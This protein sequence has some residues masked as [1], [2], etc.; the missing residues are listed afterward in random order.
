MRQNTTADACD[1]IE[2]RRGARTAAL[3]YN[4]PLATHPQAPLAQPM[5]LLEIRNVTRR[6]GDFTAVDGVS[7]AIEAGEFFTLLGPSGC[8]KTTL[9][10]MI[11]GFDLPDGGSILLERRRSGRPAAGRAPRAHGVPELRAVS[12]HDGRGQR[13]LP[14]QDGEDA[15]R[16]DRRQGRRSARGRAAHRLRQALSARALRRPEAARRDRARAG[17]ASDGAAARRAA[18][19][20][21]RQAAR[22]DADRAHQPAEGSRHHVR[23]RDARP[24]RGARAVA[25]DRRDERR[26]RRAGGRA[27]ANL[28]LSEDAVRRRLHRP[29][30]SSVGPGQRQREWHRHRRRRRAGRRARGGRAPTLAP[31]PGRHRGAAPGEDPHRCGRAAPTPPT[32]T[33]AAPSPSFSTWAT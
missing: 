25:P 27:V 26:P 14:A 24:D 29:L 20:A 28:R 15:C 12:A 4:P 32:T 10:R 13:R 30:Q 21:R 22:R 8:G 16:A 31:R 7:L 6:F 3:L 1:A 18:R 9:L 23:L 5:A 17:H 33:S 19:R 2:P 11:A